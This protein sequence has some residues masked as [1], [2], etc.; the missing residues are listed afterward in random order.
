MTEYLIILM[1]FHCATCSSLRTY[2]QEESKAGGGR[3]NFCIILRKNSYK[4]NETSKQNTTNGKTNKLWALR[5][6]V[7]ITTRE[8]TTR[9][10]VHFRVSQA[11][12]VR[13]IR[14]FWIF[15]LRWPKWNQFICCGNFLTITDE[16]SLPFH[17][18]YELSRI[19]KISCTVSLNTSD[20]LSTRKYTC[21]K[22]D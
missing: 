7:T 1:T 14:Y 10:G 19:T 15:K 9:N 17:E 2:T 3:G 5:T 20:C 22:E 8:S 16:L 11:K 12:Y 4:I 6:K 21:R 18:L 13:K